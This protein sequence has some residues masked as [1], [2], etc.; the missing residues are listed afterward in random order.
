MKCE[1]FTT[2]YT[3][4]MQLCARPATQLTRS[5]LLP[6]NRIGQSIANVRRFKWKGS[7]HEI[8]KWLSSLPIL[9]KESFWWWQCSDGYTLSLFP[10]HIPPTPFSPSLISHLASVDVKQLV[11]C[12]YPFLNLRACAVDWRT[13]F[14]GSKAERVSWVAGRAHSCISLVLLVVKT[15][16]FTATRW[17]ENITA[18]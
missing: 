8:L 7:I 18:V 6:A 3:R 2:I 17:A 11:Y 15:S 16:Y 14:A 12:T 4:E 1:G 10:H 13:Q 5:P 9:M